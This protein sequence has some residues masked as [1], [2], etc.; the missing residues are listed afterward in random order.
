[1]SLVGKT[2][3]S[4]RAADQAADLCALLVQKGARVISFPTIEIVPLP[5]SD[6]LHS[7]LHS[8]PTYDWVVFTSVNGVIHTLNA[9]REL[10]LDV[11]ILNASCVVAIG[12]STAEALRGFGVRVDIVPDQYVAESVFEAM[13]AKQPDLKGQRVLLPRAKAARDTL[14][15]LFEGAGADVTD[16]AVYETVMAD[17]QD[18][19]SALLPALRAHQVDIITFT[20]GST[21]SSFCRRLAPYLTETP[22]LLS[23]IRFAT[24]GPITAEAVVAQLGVQPIMAKPYTVAGLIEAIDAFAKQQK[25][26]VLV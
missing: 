23:G 18:D 16:L 6:E 21:V 15:T 10:G 7:V 11:S 14:V 1:M 5:L 24:I 8:L 2:I 13:Q 4:T 12:S 9:L 19:F 3:V 25:G 20:S 26:E 17:N 22:D